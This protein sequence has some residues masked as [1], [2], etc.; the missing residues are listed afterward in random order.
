MLGNVVTGSK[1]R[2][3]AP[4]CLEE[5]IKRKQHG[6]SIQSGLMQVKMQIADL[7]LDPTP[8]NLPLQQN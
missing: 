8:L 7:M 3:R 6:L 4:L 5:L 2:K 1:K